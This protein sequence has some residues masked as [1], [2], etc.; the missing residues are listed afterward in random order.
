M[1]PDD[2]DDVGAL[3]R[4]IGH[5]HGAIAGAI[6]L[7]D[8]A[9]PDVAWASSPT[10]GYAALVNLAAGFE[11]YGDGASISVITMSS[12][13][14]SV[15][16][17][18]VVRPEAASLFGPV[19]VLPTEAPNIRI[20]SVDIEKGDGMAGIPA[21]ASMLVAEAASDAAEN[22]SAWRKGRRWLRR[23]QP[24]TLPPVDATE[25][26]LKQG[27][28]YLIT[29]G[30]GGIGLALAAWLAKVA[31]ARF[32]L[33]S[34]RS[35]PPREAWEA[36]LAEPERDE[37]NAA[38][39]KSDAQYRGDGRDGDDRRRRCRRSRRHGG[40]HRKSPRMLGGPGRRHPRRRGSG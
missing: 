9:S 5:S 13:A 17:E 10:R 40:G 7:L 24:V 15:L 39:I 19:I 32:L 33:T 16:D 22:F 35:L 26:P 18:P 20:R 4:D 25:L 12:G 6:M 2:P 3:L 1:R 30:L 21:I 31:S 23:Y 11:A 14:Q 29:G 34:R 38:I 8:V 37:K 27:G 36:L 28:S